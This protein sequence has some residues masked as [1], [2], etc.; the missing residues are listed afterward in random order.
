MGGHR[1]IATI[2]ARL[3]GQS[4]CEQAHSTAT[5]VLPSIFSGSSNSTL[6]EYT[7]LELTFTLYPEIRWTI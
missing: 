2:N 6:I 1:I 5:N 7:T 3:K 4:H